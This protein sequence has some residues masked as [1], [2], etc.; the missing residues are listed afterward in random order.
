[1]SL[2]AKQNDFL[3]N[4]A[5]AVRDY[6][7]EPQLEYKTIAGVQGPLVILENVKSAKYAEIVKV[8]L[9]DGEVR[10]GQVLEVAGNKAVV[11]IFEGTSGIDNTRTK[12]KFIGDVLK[13]PISEEMLG[14]SKIFISLDNIAY[15][16]G[17]PFFQH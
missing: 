14:R 9:G 13:M 5:A 11:Q 12:C 15:F 1:M 10:S 7:V 3:I 17:F 4:A 16:C 6:R 2:T 8:T